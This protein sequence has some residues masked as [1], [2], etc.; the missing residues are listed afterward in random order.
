MGVNAFHPLFAR[1]QEVVVGL[2]GK[3]RVRRGVNLF[4]AAQ[5]IMTREN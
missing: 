5:E 3:E 2:V 1:A 4:L